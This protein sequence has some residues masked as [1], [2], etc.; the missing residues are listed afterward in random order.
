MSPLKEVYL[1]T[2]SGDINAELLSAGGTICTT[3]A[4][5]THS[6]TNSSNQ[7]V[8]FTDSPVSFGNGKDTQIEVKTRSGDCTLKIKEPEQ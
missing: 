1:K 8:F 3:S 5:K 4:K 2:F 6:F 7:K